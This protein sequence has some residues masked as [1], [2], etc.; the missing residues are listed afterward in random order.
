MVGVVGG[1]T[2]AAATDDVARRSRARI[3]P[4]VSLHHEEARSRSLPRSGARRRSEVRRPRSLEDQQA[5]SPLKPVVEML[6]HE[7]L[8]EE[9]RTCEARLNALAE[10]SLALRVR[11]DTPSCSQRRSIGAVKYVS[12]NGGPLI[13]VPAEWAKSWCGTEASPGARVPDGWEWSGDD[14]DPVRT[15]YDRACG[16]L[17]ALHSS[18]YGGVGCLRVGK[19]DALVLKAPTDTTFVALADGGALLRNV[20]FASAR[21]AREAVDAAPKWKRTRA[22]RPRSP[23]ARCRRG[24]APST[25][26]TR[27]I[28]R[29]SSLSSR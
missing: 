27:T 28:D 26:G 17:R 20:R 4:T 10:E 19:G 9:L 13:A 14:D 11:A 3:P 25:G 2:E 6:T 29:A 1:A 8:L 15:D 12:S 23:G 22:V 21:A 24:A 16:K 7:E 18:S 5:V